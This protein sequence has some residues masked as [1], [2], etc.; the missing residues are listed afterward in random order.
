MTDQEL[1][2]EKNEQQKA[3]AEILKTHAEQ[4]PHALFIMSVQTN[5]TVM[6][7]CQNMPTV[8]L[9]HLTEIVSQLSRD[10]VRKD[11]KL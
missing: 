1:R 10:A 7:Q 3:V 11:L 9:C 4:N 5:G 8:S 6:F 2:P